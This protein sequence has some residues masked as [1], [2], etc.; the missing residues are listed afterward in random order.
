MNIAQLKSEIENIA[1]ET[2][3]TFIEACSA[4]QAAAAKM[5]NEKMI[6]VIHKIKMAHLG[7]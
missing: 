1:T 5:G 6:T 2:G 3:C 7:L 4:M